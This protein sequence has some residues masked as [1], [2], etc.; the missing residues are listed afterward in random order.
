MGEYEQAIE[1][2]REEIWDTLGDPN[3]PFFDKPKEL[4]RFISDLLGVRV[5]STKGETLRYFIKDVATTE[6]TA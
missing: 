3:R 1:I 6:Q 5:F 2:C 4:K